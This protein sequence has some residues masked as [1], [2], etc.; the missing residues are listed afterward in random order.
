MSKQNDFEN[1]WLKLI[2]NAVTIAGL[3]RDD[4]SPVTDLTV[5]LHTKLEMI[6]DSV[7]THHTRRTTEVLD[8]L[9]TYFEAPQRTSEMRIA[10]HTKLKMLTSPMRE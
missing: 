5:A 6:V 4:V 3:A 2:F 7:G 8:L 10:L 9:H 1:D